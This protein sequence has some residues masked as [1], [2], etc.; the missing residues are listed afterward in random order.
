MPDTGDCH[1]IECSDPLWSSYISSNPHA[2][3]FHHPAWS[4][5]I[6]SCYGYR[7]FVLVT[8]GGS[9]Q[10][11][12]GI[13]LMEVN[14]PLTGKRWVSL[15]F[16]DYCN[17]LYDHDEALQTMVRWLVNE[18][19]QKHLKQV[20]IRWGLAW[21]EGVVQDIRL[22]R[23]TVPLDPDPEIVSAR[24]ERVHKQNAR[25]AS[26]R[27]VTLVWGHERQ[28][29][30]LFYELQVE[31]R[32][33]LGAPVQPHRYFQTLASRLF[34]LQLASVLLAYK[35]DE[36]IAG[37]VLL[38]WGNTVIAKYAASKN[39]Q[40]NL[41]PNNLLFW[42]GIRWSC[43]NGYSVFDMGRTEIENQGLHRY[44]KGWGAEEE[45]LAYSTIGAGKSISSNNDIQRLMSY[46][47]RHTPDTVCRVMG[48]LLY[49][50]VA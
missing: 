24:F 25:A 40:W 21:G 31:T 30:D 16:T 10:I 41:R 36:C 34:E 32:Q 7:P 37:L 12:G 35:E 20:E 23:Q 17:P 48:E 43:E 38:H 46:V 45:P 8:T 42:N 3:I 26:K 44:K 4:G 9:G 19:V 47:I 28:H 39:D 29:M 13:P 1:V 5:V 27:G 50:H 22:I 18:R 11:S 15:P 14:S 6:A 33:R 2:N 49:K